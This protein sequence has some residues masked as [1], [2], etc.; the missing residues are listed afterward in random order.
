MLKEDKINFNYV[1]AVVP[2]YNCSKTIERCINSLLNQTI[3]PKEI[4]IVN[5]NSIDNTG[6][7]IQKLQNIH[8]DTIILLDEK[9]QGAP[10][11]RNCGLE[12]ATGKWIQFLDA[13][14]E[15]L[16]D[17]LEHQLILISDQLEADVILGSH[18][19]FYKTRNGLTGSYIKK[20]NKPVELG[21]LT[22]SS[23]HT[24]ANLWRRKALND[25]GN[26]DE[27]LDSAQEYN[28]MWKLYLNKSTFVFDH[29]VLTWVH[30]DHL[31]SSVSRVE[32]WKDIKVRI[33]NHFDYLTRIKNNLLEQNKLLPA[34]D[35]IINRELSR[36]YFYYKID[37]G[38]IE[39]QFF[40]SLKQ[41]YKLRL[42]L[43]NR[44]K[45]LH[46]YLINHK[47]TSNKLMH[48]PQLIYYGLN[49]ARYLFSG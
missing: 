3:P 17:K 48:Y 14:D 15:I 18:K 47:L 29:V 19:T 32:E 35:A 23:G 22:Y 40:T 36:V 20:V 11:T 8:P 30:Q 44:V 21:F 26:W 5:N 38:H 10:A 42:T 39:R 41:K 6:E 2:A 9:K 24:C 25:V 12:K 16:P 7:L 1:S 4:I 49:Y 34:Y 33:N 43:G 28:L 31:Q 46:T 27:Q 13:D 37:F 45:T